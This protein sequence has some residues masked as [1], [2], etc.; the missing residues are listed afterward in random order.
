MCLNYETIDDSKIKSIL[1]C[2]FGPI[3]GRQKKCHVDGSNNVTKSREEDKETS[4]ESVSYIG[5][6][7][8]NHQNQYRAGWRWDAYCSGTVHLTLNNIDD[9]DS[10]L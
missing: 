1:I 3:H 6:I 9:Q 2:T 10:C 7:P 8:R 5:F 4:L